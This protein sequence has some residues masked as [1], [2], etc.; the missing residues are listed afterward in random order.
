LTGSAHAAVADDPERSFSQGDLGM[1]YLASSPVKHN[2]SAC[3]KRQ[4]AIRLY[5]V[6]RGSRGKKLNFADQ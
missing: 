6:E 2:L 3:E 5:A 1:K 4:E